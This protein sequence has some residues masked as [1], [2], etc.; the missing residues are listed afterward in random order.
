MKHFLRSS[1]I[2]LCSVLLVNTAFSQSLPVETQPRVWIKADLVNPASGQS[3]DA[4]SNGYHLQWNNPVIVDTFNYHLALKLDSGIT[5]NTLNLIPQ[6][7]DAEYVIYTVYRPYSRQR[8][9]IYNI[10]FDSTGYSRLTTTSIRSYSNEITYADSTAEKAVINKSVFCWKNR[11]LDSNMASFSFLGSD[12]LPYSGKF[13][14]LIIMDTMLTRADNEKIHTYLALKYGISLINLN[15]RSSA[16]TII[17]NNEINKD[18]SND[19]AGLGRDDDL[20]LYQKQSA[21]NGGE[22]ELC[23]SLGSPA[24]L[25][26]S[27]GHYL[28]NGNFM[29]WG[30]DGGELSIDT[31]TSTTAYHKYMLT[32]VWKMTR[33]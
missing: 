13:A 9:G 12:S 23:M 29:L 14:E 22:S 10:R 19:I 8:S 32:R 15:Y 5:P 26:T 20:Q 17:W 6:A 7:R 2:V 31:D 11:S 3:V 18:Y 28:P 16:D 25:N 24:V 4:R 21:A 30:H 1:F 33:A 27:N